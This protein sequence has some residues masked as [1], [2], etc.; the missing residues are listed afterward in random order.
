MISRHLLAAALSVAAAGSLAIAPAAAQAVPNLSGH[1]VL[2]VAKSDFGQAPGGPRS[3]RIEHNEPQLTIKRTIESA[4][5]AVEATLTYAV[6]GKP[7]TN[8]IGGNEVTS[9]LKWDGKVLVMASVVQTPQGPA[10]VNDRYALSA[11]G[12]TL[13]IERSIGIQGQ[14]LT[15][16][17]VFG[18]K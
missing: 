10:D 13:T 7:Y 9:T 18:K 12:A 1:W 5:G 11:D 8:T 17:L 16:T 2:D 3:D 15:Q 4:D 14:S 6:D